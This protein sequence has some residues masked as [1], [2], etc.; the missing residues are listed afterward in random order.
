ML[1][2]A[3]MLALPVVVAALAPTLPPFLALE[4]RV[5]FQ[6]AS[7]AIGS[8][9]GSDSTIAGSASLIERTAKF[10]VANEAVSVHIEGHVGI[11][12]PPEIA[13]EYSQA[14]AMLV[15]EDIGARGV[16]CHRISIAGW[17]Y[18]AAQRALDSKHPNARAA[19]AGY[20]WAEIFLRSEDESGHVLEMPVRPDYYLALSSPPPPSPA[21]TATSLPVFYMQPGIAAGESFG[22]HLFEPRYRLLASRVASSDDKLFIYCAAAPFSSL[23]ESL[24]DLPLGAPLPSAG[25]CTLARVERMSPVYADGTVD[26]EGVGLESVPLREV[27]LEEGTGGARPIGRCRATR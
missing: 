23:G 4:N 14:R 21:P 12:A 13:F 15:A 19:Q 5:G 7:L 9:D 2:P 18:M 6:F 20:G 8:E 24:Y 22:I 10:L 27:V 17:G 1:T 3:N 26:V 25:A 11:S 16:P